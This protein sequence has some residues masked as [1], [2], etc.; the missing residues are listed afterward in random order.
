[1]GFR[2]LGR[3]SGSPLRAFLAREPR[4]RAF[5][6]DSVCVEDLVEPG[7][8]ITVI[9]LL[10]AALISVSWR[11]GI[12]KREEPDKSARCRYVCMWNHGCHVDV[13]K[14]GSCS[15]E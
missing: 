9:L 1:M 10:A 12:E 11:G 4:P 15:E 5:S 2:C 8:Q 3:V 13:L 7:S 6:L 14:G